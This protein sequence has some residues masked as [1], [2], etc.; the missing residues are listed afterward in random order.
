MEPAGATWGVARALGRSSERAPA[1]VRVRRSDRPSK[2]QDQG[3]GLEPTSHLGRAVDEM[4]A[5]G[6]QPERFRQLEQ[7]RERNARIIEQRP[8][9]VF[10]NLT[11]RQSTFTR[12]DIA[13]EVFRYIDKGEQFR[14]LMARL[15]ASR[16]LVALGTAGPLAEEIRNTT[17]A[18]LR[19]E[20]RMAEIAFDMAAA[21]RHPVRGAELTPAIS[22]HLELS[23][24]QREAVRQMTR[25]PNIEVL[26]GL[27]GTGKS[28]AVG[29]ARDAWEASGYRVRGAALSGIAA[30]NLE[31]SSGVA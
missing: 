24:E 21:D 25:A 6:E 23:S 31:K 1:A 11:R 28:A 16:E 30:E 9:I 8:E 18:M 27:A 10:D 7:V 19:V 13:R 29:A 3:V 4:R 15:E 2:L 5:R 14:N 20:E 12:R 22:R 17:R 26:A